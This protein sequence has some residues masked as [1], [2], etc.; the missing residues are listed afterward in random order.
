MGGG[1][2]W[3]AMGVGGGRMCGEDGLPNPPAKLPPD[4]ACLPSW[5]YPGYSE[6]RVLGAPGP[7]ELHLHP[8]P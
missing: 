6:E 8:Q 1:K 3:L 2:E 4:P 7:G 5:G